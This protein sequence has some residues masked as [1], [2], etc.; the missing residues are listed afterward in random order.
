MEVIDTLHSTLAT[1]HTEVDPK[2]RA[3][4]VVKYFDDKFIDLLSVVESKA[5]I[6]HDANLFSIVCQNMK[7]DLISLDT[8]IKEL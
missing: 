6:S 3:K 7:N 8:Y 2:Q 5:Q 4:L 1:K